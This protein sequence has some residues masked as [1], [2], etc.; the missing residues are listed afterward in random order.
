[1]KR[2][3]LKYRKEGDAAFLSHREAMRA[4]ERALRRSGIPLAFS[5]G[6]SPRPRMSF[7]PALP[8]G[9]AAEAEYVELAVE[10]DVDMK[11]AVERLSLALPT[12]LGVSEIQALSPTM[13]KL[14]RWARY[15]LFRLQDGEK[16]SYLLLILGGK[17]QGRL[18]DAMH[19]MADD[20]DLDEARCSVTRVGLYASP[21]E[22]FEDAEG[23]VMFYDGASGELR[24][25]EEGGFCP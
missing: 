3:L 25:I 24:E 20:G 8:L 10:G 13:P 9:V 14:S 15:G 17:G 4:M 19:A 18:K 23:K 12:G 6:F 7:S 2:L 5:E 22:V 21:E 1:M 16:R 11:E